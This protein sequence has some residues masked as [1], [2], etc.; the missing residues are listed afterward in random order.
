MPSGSVHAAASLLAAVPVALAAGRAGGDGAALAAGIGCV[1][2]IPLTPD[3]DLAEAW[4]PW[5]EELL[6]M[7]AWGG[8]I[9]FILSQEG[10]I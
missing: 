1:A 5:W 4:M 2:G 8:F 9:T 6:A 3:W 10:M 7:F